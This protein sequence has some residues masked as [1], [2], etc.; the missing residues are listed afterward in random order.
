VNLDGFMYGDIA[1]SNLTVPFLFMHSEPVVP[2]AY[3]TQHI[4]DSAD[5]T[6][7]QV[8]IWDSR[9]ANFGDVSLYGGVFGLQDNLGAIDGERCVE[10]QT[11]YVAAFFD[12]HL[13]SQSAPLLDRQSPA[14][15]EVDLNVHAPATGSTPA[16]TAGV[17]TE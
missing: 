2:Q 16:D 9:H 14:F 4:Y 11:T 6:A 7:Y 3:I 5:A 15:P 13:K 17:T 10:I 12:K 1:D 8:K